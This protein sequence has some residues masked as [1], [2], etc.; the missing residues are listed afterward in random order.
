MI[1]PLVSI[2]TKKNIFFSLSKTPQVRG[3]KMEK[4]VL[5]KIGSWKTVRKRAKKNIVR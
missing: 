3:R 2:K 4:R 5:G 1:I